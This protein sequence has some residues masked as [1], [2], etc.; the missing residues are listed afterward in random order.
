M[1]IKPGADIRGL[2][3][4]MRYPLSVAERIWEENGRS[5]G[6]TIT[7]GLNG[8]HSAG[9]LHPCGLA[10]DLRTRYFTSEIASDVARRLRS[11]LKVV[12]TNYGVKLESDHIHVQWRPPKH[13]E[14]HY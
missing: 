6:I 5:E 2:R 1:D 13:L 12:D 11:T 3:N 10:V 7:C 9:S 8:V 14:H 4:V